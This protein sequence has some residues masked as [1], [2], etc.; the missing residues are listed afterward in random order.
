MLL[1]KENVHADFQ[2]RHGR[3]QL[4]PHKVGQ[5]QPALRVPHQ[6]R[7]AL[8]QPGHRFAGIVVV[9]Q[10]A[11]AVRLAF[12][13]LE[14][15]Q[16][17]QLPLG[18][19]RPSRLQQL[20]E[21]LHPGVQVGGTGVAVHHGHRQARRRGHHV[22]FRVDFGQLL[23][24]H[25][26]GKD[27]C[28]RRNVARAHGNA[29]GGGHDR[30]GVA[31]RRAQRHTRLQFPGGVQQPCALLRQHPGRVPGHKHLRQDIPQPP[32]QTALLQKPVELMDHAGVEILCPAVNGEHTGGLPHAQHPFPGELPMYIPG[33]R[34][35][36]SDT[37]H[38]L[39]PVPDG[40][41]KVGDTP[42]LRDVEPE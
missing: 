25:R 13:R 34:C 4:R 6:Q 8:L 29:V 41:V 17:V 31:L 38:M 1:V 14:V 15:Q 18:K 5:V 19:L 10:H 36:I 22:D 7:A 20:S 23:F 35:E 40:P 37:P 24:Q 32:G 42:P 21:Q 33:K 26:H 3:I 27:G 39:L 9:A 28:A 30:P 2:R 12:Q 11:P 16:I